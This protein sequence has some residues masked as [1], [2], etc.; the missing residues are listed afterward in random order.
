MGDCGP[1]FDSFPRN[2][3]NKFAGKEFIKYHGAVACGPR[4]AV[5]CGPR[6]AGSR[7]AARRRAVRSRVACG[8]RGAVACSRAAWACGRVRPALR[9]ASRPSRSGPRPGWRTPSRRAAG[10]GPARPMTRTNAVKL[11]LRRHGR[12]RRRARSRAKSRAKSRARSRAWD[13]SQSL[14]VRRPGRPG[15]AAAPPAGVPH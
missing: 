5:A 3:K 13:E 14:R 10:P 11:G 8:P 15:P 1:P 9:A 2:L 4:G 6:C 12:R 7:R